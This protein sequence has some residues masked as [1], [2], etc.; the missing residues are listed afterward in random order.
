MNIAWPPEWAPQAATLLAWPRATGDCAENLEAVRDTIAAMA[1]A[2][3]AYQHVILVAP[4]E[5][6]RNAISAHPLLSAI[7]P[8]LTIIDCPTNDIWARDFGPLCVSSENKRACIDFRFDGWRGQYTAELDDAVTACLNKQNVLENDCYIRDEHVLEGGSIDQNGNGVLLTTRSSLL[9]HSR[10][11]GM[12]SK[13][14]E[15]LF[16]R[17]LGIDTVHWLNNGALIGDDTHGHIDTLARFVSEGTIVYQGCSN[18]ADPHYNDLAAMADELA[19]LRDKQ[20]QPYKLRELPMPEAI[21]DS[22]TGRR[23]PAGYANFLIANQ[24]ILMPAY[25]DPVDP[26]AADI[27]QTCFP[28]RVIIAIDARPLIRHGGALH[29]AAMQIPAHE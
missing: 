6:C 2:L 16:R 14:F 29:C 11:T 21:F 26:K 12:D 19:E 27:L 24:C 20:S 15:H 13:D 7:K 17:R 22:E 8:Q 4:D 10:N 5:E 9:V 18:P 25:A 23:L 28:N 3:H 1:Q